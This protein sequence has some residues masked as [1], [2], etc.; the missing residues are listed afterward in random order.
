M[1]EKERKRE[2]DRQK[3]EHSSIVTVSADYITICLSS[4]EVK[5]APTINPSAQIT[6]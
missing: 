1:R 4:L 2:T 6:L 3:G 5:A